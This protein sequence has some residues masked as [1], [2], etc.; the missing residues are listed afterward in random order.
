MRDVRGNLSCLHSRVVHEYGVG[1]EAL[2][3][4]VCDTFVEIAA[5][6]EG[7]ARARRTARSAARRGAAA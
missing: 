6:G 7:V 5:V 3:R 1:R 2:V 4:L